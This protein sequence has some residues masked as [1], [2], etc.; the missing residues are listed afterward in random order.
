MALLVVLVFGGE[1]CEGTGYPAENK[2]ND[3]YVPSRP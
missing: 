2:K 1:G 3:K